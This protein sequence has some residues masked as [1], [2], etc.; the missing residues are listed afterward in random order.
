MDLAQLVEI[1]DKQEEIISELEQEIQ[2]LLT[3]RNKAEGNKIVEVVETFES[4]TWT[5]L[6]WKINVTLSIM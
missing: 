6:W 3:I 1:T 4:D 2:E 5:G